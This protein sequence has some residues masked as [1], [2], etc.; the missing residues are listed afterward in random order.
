MS[1]SP[2]RR[3]S[4][5][6]GR[7][8]DREPA[9]ELPEHRQY[10]DNILRIPNPNQLGISPHER[11]S[12]TDLLQ[13]IDRHVPGLLAELR[14]FQTLCPTMPEDERMRRGMAI[15]LRP[16]RIDYR[17]FTPEQQL[18]MQR[19]RVLQAIYLVAAGTSGRLP[20][21]LRSPSPSRRVTRSMK[22]RRTLPRS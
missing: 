2:S 13:A 1:R 19:A 12:H 21:P 11:Q 7:S 5:A 15:I 14:V 9:F 6:R 16:T 17:V 8:A 10:F 3:S 18:T 4:S 20:S 22:R